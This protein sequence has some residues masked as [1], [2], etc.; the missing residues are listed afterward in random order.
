MLPPSLLADAD[1]P[2]EP[3]VSGSQGPP[4][5]ADIFRI[6]C[7]CTA[8]AHRPATGARARKTKT[9]ALFLSPG[10]GALRRSE[11]DARAHGLL[12]NRSRRAPELLGDLSGWGSRLRECLQSFQLTGAPGCAI[13]RWTS[14]HR[15]Y[16]TITQRRAGMVMIHGSLAKRAPKF[17]RNMLEMVQPAQSRVRCCFGAA[18]RRDLLPRPCPRYSPR[19]TA[20]ERRRAAAGATHLR[21]NARHVT[22]A[23]ADCTNGD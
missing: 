18:R 5:Q 19:L 2:G 13:V 1:R 22:V 9:R 12:L 15:S 16:S 3:V 6:G 14:C 20:L 7:E 4:L 8:R 11:G 23:A 17:N 10:S 21:V